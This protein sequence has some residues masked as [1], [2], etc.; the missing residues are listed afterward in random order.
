MQ[1]SCSCTWRINRSESERSGPLPM[2]GGT[3]GTSVGGFPIGR[4]R[5]SVCGICS[6]TT[7]FTSTDDCR[8]LLHRGSPAELPDVLV[9]SLSRHRETVRSIHAAD[10][11]AGHGRVV[12]P[13]ALARKYP[14][15]PTDW[16]WQVAFPQQR[17][18]RNE[19]T[20][21]E[22]RHHVHETVIERAVKQ[23][24]TA[25]GLSKR[26]ICHTLRHSFAIHLLMAGYDIRTVQELLGHKD[27]STTMIYTHVLNRG[28]MAVRSPADALG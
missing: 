8:R 3:R 21:E 22:G 10:L 14:G 16:R 27:V 18:W 1:G 9:I 13:D 26:A 24:V 12:L 28:G 6:G 17:R 2:R 5:C 15:A 7:G 20:G 25:A 19:E 11:S 4:K 23:A